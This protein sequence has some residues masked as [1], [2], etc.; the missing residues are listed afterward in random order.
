MFGY[1]TPLKDELKVKEYRFYQSTYCGLCHC[2]GKRVCHSSRMTLSYDTVF[3]A[4]VRFA[5]A[6]E[7]IEFEEKRCGVSPFKKKVI[8]SDNPSLRYSAAAGALLAY[9]K[10]ADDARD[11]K[12]IRKIAAKTALLFSHG[13]KKK[14]ALP[15]LD[16]KISEYLD[17][18]NELESSD[19]VSAD[20]TAQCFGEILKAVFAEGLNGDKKRIAGEIGFHVGKWIYLADAADDY[21][22]DRKKGEFNPLPDPPDREALKC[23]MNIELSVAALAYELSPA[24]DV[25]INAIIKN[26]LYLGLPAKADKLIIEDNKKKK[27]YRKAERNL[28]R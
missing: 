8:V 9:Y 4:L 1:V 24:N 19:N 11:K 21:E 14:A 5:L 22:S 7:K 23:A 3:L 6:D 17:K 15:Q 16:K 27:D 10:I 20:E 26:I 25:G 28:S 18:L 12:G 2:M 13:I